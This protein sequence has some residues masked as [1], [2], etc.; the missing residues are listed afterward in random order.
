MAER[1]NK[2]QV[3]KSFMKL[4]GNKV[5]C[6]LCSK[7]LS[8]PGGQTSSLHAHLRS[9]HPCESSK[10]YAT[11]IIA[12]FVAP[13]QCSYSRKEKITMAIGKLI[14]G[15]ML[16]ISIV[17]SESMRELLAL[18]E[19]GYQL[20]CRQTM[21]DRLDR[22]K[23]AVAD[24]VME[25]LAAVPH[26]WITTD[27]WTSLSNEA[28]LSFTASYIDP[29]WKLKTPTLAALFL[30]ERHTQAVIA[31]SL[32]DVACQWN[33]NDMMAQ[34]TF[35][36]PVDSTTG[37]MSTAQHTNCNCASRPR[38]VWTKSPITQSRSAS[39][40]LLVSWGISRTVQWLLVSL[41]SVR[42]P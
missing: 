11:V 39:E 20:P 35:G 3:W 37:Q 7:E 2:S 24:K 31:D 27:I 15:N 5:R 8:V 28:N 29:A 42:R 22:Q 38:W 14:V 26:I 32:H 34:R 12:S 40:Q 10:S 19:P 30:E 1:A 17:E 18:V 6:N 33:V 23:A 16:P 41:R 4:P 13:R 36:M 9:K 25:E 21:S